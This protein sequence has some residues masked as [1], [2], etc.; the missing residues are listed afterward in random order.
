[1]ALAESSQELF[2]I[3][4]DEGIYTPT[5]VLMGG[6]DSVAHC[7]AAVQEMFAEYLYRGLMA[8]LDDVLGYA[9][10]EEKLLHLLAATLAICE[11]R[12]LKLNPA[13]CDFYKEEVKWCGRIISASGVKHDPKRIQALCALAEPTNGKEL[14]QFICALNWMRMSIPGYNVLV[15]PMQQCM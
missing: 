1:M 10:S 11:K 8:W 12:G 13:K 4:T 6:S 14:Q 7:Q 2:S 15:A 5:R 9:T 3:L